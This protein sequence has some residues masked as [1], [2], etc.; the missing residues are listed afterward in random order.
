MKLLEMQKVSKTYQLGKANE[1][2]ALKEVDVSFFTN[3]MVAITGVSGSGKST[4]L[5]IM[6]Q[7]DVPT[8]GALLYKGKKV[9]F[10][11]RE[12][13]KFRNRELGFIPQEF[14]L[15]PNET[16]FE[17]VRVPLMFHPNVRWGEM[18]SLVEQALA[19]V[20]MENFLKRKIKTLSGGQKQRIAIA[21]AIVNRPA[22]LLADEPTGALDSATAS[23]I[24]TV[25]KRLKNEERA[26]V[27]VTH[28]FKV[29]EA[30][31][32]I[33]PIQDGELICT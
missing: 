26:I 33:I 5:N 21:R 14:G 3:E 6:G 8:S 22:L 18:K 16:A 31:D 12:R 20:G 17:N 11:E 19:D 25:F 29:A 28:D 13:A 32:R 7:M 30:C 10:S 9:N 4:L 1:V 2:H 24:V 15:L 23:E 27:L